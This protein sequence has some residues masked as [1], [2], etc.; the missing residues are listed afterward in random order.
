MEISKEMLD[1][2]KK[3]EGEFIENRKNIPVFATDDD[4]TKDENY[5][6]CYLINFLLVTIY[7]DES[8]Y[9]A[10]DLILSENNYDI[11]SLF[12]TYKIIYDETIRNFR[13]K[14]KNDTL[15]NGIN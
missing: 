13:I 10:A 1:V 8:A 5:K 2:K 9:I 6:K 14:L 11:N 12:D 7:Q 4:L 15:N 3:L